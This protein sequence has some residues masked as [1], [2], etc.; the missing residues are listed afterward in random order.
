[1]NFS[2][3]RSKL[4]VGGILTALIPMAVTSY[5]AITDSAKAVTLLSKVNEQFIAEGT[6]MQ[7]AATLEGELKSVS[8]FA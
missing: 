7:V 8:A 3:I 1:M 5:I 6:A 4:F 2:S